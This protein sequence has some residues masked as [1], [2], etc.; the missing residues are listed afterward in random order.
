MMADI[1]DD[2]RVVGVREEWVHSLSGEVQRFIGGIQF[3]DSPRDPEA[4]ADELTSR[5]PDPASPLEERLL[6][7]QLLELAVWWAAV[8]HQQLHHGMG[9]SCAFR[10]EIA[11]H[12]AWRGHDRRAKIVFRDWSSPKNFYRAALRLTGMSVHELRSARRE[13]IRRILALPAAR[14]GV[15]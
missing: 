1:S 6:R 13:D 9:P 5:I 4:R 11:V 10:A 7:G 2:H 3:S 12:Q 8:A 15:N 14:L